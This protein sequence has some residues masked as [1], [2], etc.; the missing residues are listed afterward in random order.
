MNFRVGVGGVAKLYNALELLTTENCVLVRTQ[1]L[2]KLTLAI[3]SDQCDVVTGVIGLTASSIATESGAGVPANALLTFV[4]VR[5][6][7]NE[8]HNVPSTLFRLLVCL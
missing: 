1:S 4:V 3:I 2:S 6:A 5:N 8:G 7:Q